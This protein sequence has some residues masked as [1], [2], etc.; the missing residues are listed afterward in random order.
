MVSPFM[1]FAKGFLEGYNDKVAQEAQWEHEMLL[2]QA[3]ADAANL[4]DD[5]QYFQVELGDGRVER[6]FELP[7]PKQYKGDAKERT[8]EYMFRF[9]NDKRL[10]ADILDWKNTDQVAYQNV[11]A[12][13]DQGAIN[14]MDAHRT[15]KGDGRIVN[16]KPAFN[17]MKK[18]HHFET[19][20]D[21]VLLGRIPGVD[22]NTMV[23]MYEDSNGAKFYETEKFNAGSY[24]YED[25]NNLYAAAYKLIGGKRDSR[26]LNYYLS[27]YGPEYWRAYKKTES[28]WENT[29]ANNGY[30]DITNQADLMTALNDDAG[31]KVVP[32]NKNDLVQKVMQNET[33]EDGTRYN[34]QEAEREVIQ[35]LPFNLDKMHKLM[36]MGSSVNHHWDE[37]AYNYWLITN[38]NDL[39]TKVFQ[40]KGGTAMYQDR[41]TA[42]EDSKRTIEQLIDLY[43]QPGGLYVGGTAGILK[44]VESLFGKQGFVE[45]IKSLASK[46]NVTNGGNLLAD[47]TNRV[48]QAAGTAGLSSNAAQRQVLIELLAYQ[49]AAA[50]QGGTGGR[51][52]SD[53]DVAR[54]SKALGNSFFTTRDLNITRLKTLGKMMDDMGKLNK[55][56]VQAVDVEGLKAAHMLHMFTTGVGTD[57]LSTGWMM[58]RLGGIESGIPSAAQEDIDANRKYFVTSAVEIALEGKTVPVL[59][60]MTLDEFRNSSDFKDLSPQGQNQAVSIFK[61]ISR[62]KKV[63]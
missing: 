41:F 60:S 14:Y 47:M 54:I 51:T 8:K 57:K 38:P 4:K 46:Y 63:K 7:N 1:A 5:K 22:K 62:S 26:N 53:Q 49:M 55:H 52:I 6:Y 25:K 58:N 35:R 24:G 28:I 21:D 34:A 20:F 27:T 39:A 16:I 18:G 59:P 11:S 23:K 50:I 10:A 9:F 48:N 31:F 44:L 15:E 3:K 19:R 29:R 32:D 13:L 17:K 45:Q 40:M 2:A 36:K 56:Y 37:D 61:R 43:N 12:M 30:F 33:K 42:S